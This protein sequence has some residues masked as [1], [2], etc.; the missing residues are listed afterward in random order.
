MIICGK[1]YVTK[2]NYVT[3]KLF[4]ATFLQRKT[5]CLAD[6]PLPA[7]SGEGRGAVCGSTRT[8]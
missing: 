4:I 3:K 1:K 2:D 6:P 8:D 7:P 5:D